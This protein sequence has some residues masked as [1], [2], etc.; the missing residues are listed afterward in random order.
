M[1]YLFVYKRN[2]EEKGNTTDMTL[3][4]QIFHLECFEIEKKG[5]Y[6]TMSEIY[7]F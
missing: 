2:E 6:D 3:S 1:W 5:K 7:L 4:Y